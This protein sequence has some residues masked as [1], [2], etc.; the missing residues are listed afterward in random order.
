VITGAVG[1]GISRWSEIFFLK[2]SLE[3]TYVLRMVLPVLY[4]RDEGDNMMIR[5]HSREFV[6]QG[7]CSSGTIFKCTDESVCQDCY[8]LEDD[9]KLFV[10]GA[11]FRDDKPYGEHPF[12]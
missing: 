6:E 10:H 3:A 8:S 7:S 1:V 9:E 4:A 5:Q 12:L 11:I 2:M